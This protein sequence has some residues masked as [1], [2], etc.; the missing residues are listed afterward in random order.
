[1]MVLVQSAHIR[2]KVS[3]RI[4]KQHREIETIADSAFYRS[5]EIDGLDQD[6]DQHCAIV[7]CN[8]IS[9]SPRK[10]SMSSR[11]IPARKRIVL[12]AHD[13]KKSELVAWALAH[14]AELERHDLYAT[15]T[16]GGLIAAE[17]GLKVSRFL[18][19]PLGGDLQIGAAIAEQKLDLLIFFWDPLAAQPH[20]PDVKALLRIAVVWN[21]PIA[22]NR[23]TADYLFSSPLIQTNYQQ[24]TTLLPISPGGA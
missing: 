18:S 3:S 6:S 2:P 20:D 14:R 13:A 16:T 23:A 11:R 19:G 4:D 15:G 5:V 17:L 21:I 12:V 1:M 24:T 7:Q 10:P 9:C 8:R 22:N